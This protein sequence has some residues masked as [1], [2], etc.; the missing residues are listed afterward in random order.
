MSC[1]HY[2][3]ESSLTKAL[4]EKLGNYVDQYAEVVEKESHLSKLYKEDLLFR[5][6]YMRTSMGVDYLL[7]CLLEPFMPSFL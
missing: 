7:A 2:S 6:T 1:T 3:L 5:F 4:A